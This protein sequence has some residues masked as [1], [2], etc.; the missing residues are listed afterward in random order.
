MIGGTIE[1]IVST[2]ACVLTDAPVIEARA[3]GVITIAD[4]TSLECVAHRRR[5]EI[6]ALV[7]ARLDVSGASL[8][9]EALANLIRRRVPALTVSLG[10]APTGA[11]AISRERRGARGTALCATALA[12]IAAGEALTALNMITAPCPASAPASA[13]VRYDRNNR[14]ARASAPIAAGDELGRFMTPAAPLTVEDGQP[15]TLLVQMGPALIERSVE[16][17]QPSTGGA[18][19]VRDADGAVFSAQVL[20]AGAP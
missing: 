8:T 7:I 9:R 18:V 15:L 6:G 11:I 13:S 1:L 3:D 16:A 10:G 5:D 12:P 2:A 14:I 4:A 19:F 17:L 20:D